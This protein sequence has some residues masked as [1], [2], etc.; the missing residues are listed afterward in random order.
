M[1]NCIYSMWLNILFEPP[2]FF[3]EKL[4]QNS[5]SIGFFD[6]RIFFSLHIHGIFLPTWNRWMKFPDPPFVQVCDGP[7]SSSPGP[8]VGLCGLCGRSFGLK[9]WKGYIAD[10]VWLGDVSDVSVGCFLFCSIL[11]CFFLQKERHLN[12]SMVERFAILVEIQMWYC[13]QLT[14]FFRLSMHLLLAPCYSTAR[15]CSS[16]WKVY[17][18]RWRGASDVH[19][20]R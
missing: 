10:T 6:H 7:G 14:I 15:G 18:H 16:S 4:T 9:D 3:M 2:W 11:I 1:V 19:R 17:N 5:F 20:P 8:S 13:N 12:V